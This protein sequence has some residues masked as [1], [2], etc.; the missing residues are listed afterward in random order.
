MTAGSYL[1][2]ARDGFGPALTNG[3]AAFGACALPALPYLL[4]SG[5]GALVASLALVA[6]VAGVV[7]WL[8]PD[9]G[10]LAV[11]ETFGVLVVAAAL[12]S[13][14]SVW[15]VPSAGV[16]AAVAATRIAFAAK[17]ATAAEVA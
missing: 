16:L 7:S 8:R 3:A 4:G 13:I 11:V 5:T 17:R 15:P 6:A 1:S 9:K 14:T 2:D 10:V 12:A